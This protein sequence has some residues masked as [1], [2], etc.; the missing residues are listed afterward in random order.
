MTRALLAPVLLLLLGGCAELQ[1]IA[2][3]AVQR[4]RL[5]FRSAS[6]QALDLEGATIG[7]TY[8]VENPNS[9]GAKVARLGYGVE[10]E[11]TRVVTGDMP[12][13]LVIPANGRAPVTFPVR[14]RFRDVPGIAA[15]F[16]RRDAISYRLS[17]TIGIET[18]LGV[19]DLPL[20]HDD[21]VSL[22]RLPDFALEGL[23]VR[24]V[25]FTEVGLEV[26]VAVKNPNAFPIPA[27][28]LDYALS[29]AGSAVAHGDGRPV[30]LVPGGGRSVVAIPLTVNLAQVGR[31][32][33]A[34]VKGGPVDVGLSG[35]ADL[36]GIPVPLA[37][38]ARLPAR[39]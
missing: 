8:D 11:G 23:S 24:S 3:G 39:R 20:S 15:L 14:V 37:L 27:S 19:L 28:R 34:L 33:S 35:T 29:L 13:G 30:Q 26:R 22:P 7:F 18:P 6:L 32:A 31:V 38:S 16:G 2:E 12:G 36:A 1:K 4:P 25:S 9:F 5:T 17:G 10:V 21:R